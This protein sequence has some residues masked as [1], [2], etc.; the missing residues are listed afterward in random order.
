MFVF[1]TMIGCLPLLIS[2]SKATM[3]IVSLYGAGLLVGVAFIVIIPEASATLYEAL[4]A[5]KAS[6]KLSGKF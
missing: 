5:P 3:N 6:N 1:S 2:H 4:L